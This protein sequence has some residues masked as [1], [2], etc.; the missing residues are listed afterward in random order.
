MI[1]EEVNIDLCTS[2]S[3][4]VELIFTLYAKKCGK[5][6]WG[7]KTPSYTPYLY[8][9]NDHFPNSKFLHLIRDGRDV[10]ISNSRQ[11]WG[12]TSLSMIVED[13][14][15]VVSC[16]RK[17]GKV[18][19]EE[20]Y[21]ELRYEDLIRNPKENRTNVLDFLE[22]PFDNSVLRTHGGKD[23]DLLPQRSVAFHSNLSKQPDASLAYKWKNELGD[24]DQVLCNLLAGDLLDELEYPKGC[25]DS[26]TVKVQGRRLYHYL[27]Q[28][29]KWR[30]NK[31]KS[32]I[33]RQVQH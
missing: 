10:A 3:S 30:L 18:I 26:S 9:L 7:D 11:P 12:L 8:L 31:L 14:K 4:T 25:P 21:M 20:R 33:P 29:V 15:H 6:V 17:I 19:G 24:A 13:W 27:H 22:L 23:Q 1:P 2:F 32:R 16:T 28:G 5:S